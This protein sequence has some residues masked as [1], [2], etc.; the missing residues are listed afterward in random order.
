MKSIVVYFSRAGQNYFQGSLKNIEIGNTEVIAKY[1]QEEL[2]CDAFKLE[3]LQPYSSDYNECIEQAKEDL[4]RGA[5]P[6]LMEYLDSLEEYE[7]IYLGFP[8]Y[9][10][11]MPMCVF[12]FLESYD[13]RDKKIYPFVT[14]EGSGFGRSLE[15]LK[16]MCPNSEIIDGLSILGSRVFDEKEKVMQWLKEEN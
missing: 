11:T 12:T 2:G 9:W 13:L 7:S 14:H 8:N 6:E 16:R 1:I 10:G 3:P 5:R 15:D 4:E